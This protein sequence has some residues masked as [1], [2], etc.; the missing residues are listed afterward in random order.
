MI[1][2]FPLH[3]ELMISFI[4]FSQK[5]LIYSLMELELFKF[6][7]AMKLP[8]VYCLNKLFP[9][10]IT[11]VPFLKPIS[12]SRHVLKIFS[13]EPKSKRCFLQFLCWVLFTCPIFQ[14]IVTV[15]VA[16]I[17]IIMAGFLV[18]LEGKYLALCSRVKCFGV[19][20]QEGV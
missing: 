11:I 9:W 6:S 2:F 4:K 14:L 16:K 20:T 5:G 15:P 3:C 18:H 10:V 13:E 1:E 8:G 19:V 17:I 7:Q 12:S